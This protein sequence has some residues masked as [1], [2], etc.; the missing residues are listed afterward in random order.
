MQSFARS[1]LGVRPAQG[2]CEDM[3]RLKCLNCGLTV[4][5]KGSKG[6]LCPRCLV[7]E[8]RAVTLI[9]VSDQPSSRAM[10]GSLRIRTKVEGERHTVSI[11]GELDVGSAQ[12]L[13]ETLAEA[14]ASGAKE[15]VLDLG[16]VEFMDSTGLSAILQGKRLC[17]AHQCRYSLT[18][19]QRPVERVFEATGVRRRLSFRRAAEENASQGS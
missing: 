9:P 3:L 7:R 13:E 8:E 14:C 6:D 17:E 1:V 15:L 11:S 18:P 5:Y 10:M 4:P 19:A 12:V 2:S 16:R